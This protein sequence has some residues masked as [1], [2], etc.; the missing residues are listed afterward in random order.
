MRDE[1]IS[2][3]I[4]DEYDAWIALYFR[5]RLTAAYAHTAGDTP[6]EDMAKLLA[7]ADSACAPPPTAEA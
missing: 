7:R 5:N 1:P 4:P 3:A 2:P 6:P